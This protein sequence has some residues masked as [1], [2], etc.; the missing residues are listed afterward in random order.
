[1]K[2]QEKDSG[3]ESGDEEEKLICCADV[4]EHEYNK[5]VI[6]C[7]TKLQVKASQ[8]QSRPQWT[9]KYANRAKKPKICPTQ[10]QSLPSL[11]ESP[12]FPCTKCARV[13]R[14]KGGLKLQQ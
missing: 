10:S 9:P 11:E 13:C 4:E 3:E 7:K 5:L 8:L 6:E 14:S 12:K 2:M 1:M